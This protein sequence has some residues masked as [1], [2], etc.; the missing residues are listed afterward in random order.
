MSKT[1]GVLGLVLAL[2]VPS[3]PLIA[4]SFDG[5]VPLMCAVIQ[6]MECDAGGEC[7]RRTAQ[8]VNLPTFIKLD[9]AKKTMSGAG[10]DQRTAPIGSF[11]RSNGRIIMQGGQEG[12]A[13][14]L[15]IDGGTGSMSA[16]VVDHDFAFLVFGACTP[17]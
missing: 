13:W 7:H 17:F 5:S 15:V 9:F 8:G 1:L 12:R 11:E 4:A 16:G 6:V 2:A 14:S 10:G 3:A